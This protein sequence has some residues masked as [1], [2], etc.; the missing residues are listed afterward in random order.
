MAEITN[1][2]GIFYIRVNSGRDSSGKKLRVQTSYTPK[3]HTPAAARKEV[4]KYAA[5]FEELVKSGKYLS[6]EKITFCQYVDKWAEEWAALHLS[7]QM[8][9]GYRELIERR[10]VPVFGGM[11]MSKIT[12]S[13]VQGI[14][15]S[16]R[17]EG[18]A[19]ATIN[20]TV[21]AINSVFKYAYR[22]N[23]IQE[24]PCDRCERLK[25]ERKN[26]LHYW[27]EEQAKRFLN[28]ALTME[29]T[30]TIKGHT[31]TDDTGK[32]YTV[33]DYTESHPVPLQIQVYFN[34]AIYGGFRRSEIIA[35]K[36]KDIDFENRE[37][38]INKAAT[39]M[40]KKGQYTKEPKTA[41]AEREIILPEV[42]FRLLKKWKA[43]ERELMFKLGTAWKGDRKNMDENY[44]FI[45]TGNGLMMNLDTPYQRLKYIIER[46]NARVPKEKQLPSIRLHDL[47][48]TSATLLIG[49]GADIETVAKRLGHARPSTTLDIYGHALKSKDESAA[50][51]LGDLLS[52]KKA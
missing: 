34:L 28:E 27:D 37:I 13:H 49:S 40:K 26:E 18:K 3:A 1:R 11:K 48:H 14:I 45:Q 24:N 43:E 16:M 42:C 29:Y 25:I 19:A 30:D 21:C 7:E 9:A 39:R 20:R 36:W 41:A 32:Q 4:E 50:L 44:V 31:R 23:V 10:A 17:A 33:K 5:D 6:G 35:L 12:A 38:D 46:Y 51:I 47:R 8:T 52:Q 15:T 22:M 2:N